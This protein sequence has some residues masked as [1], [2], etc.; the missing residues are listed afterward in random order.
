MT[1]S[2]SATAHRSTRTT[3]SSESST[4][5]R[6]LTI[7]RRR[8]AFSATRISPLFTQKKD[9]IVE[10]TFIEGDSNEVKLEKGVRYLINPGSVGQ[11]R[12]RNPRAS[13]A[14]YDSEARTSSSTALSTTSWRPRGKYWPKSFLLPWP[15]GCPW[16]SE[17]SP[18]ERKGAKNRGAIVHCAFQIG[19]SDF[20]LQLQLIVPPYVKV[21]D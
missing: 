1:R 19:S 5:P 10:G 21:W 11:P 8:S 14:I 17:D 20:I 2:R 4:P 15:K 16:E 7:S 3:T 9:S 13:C 12:D 6:P 18:L